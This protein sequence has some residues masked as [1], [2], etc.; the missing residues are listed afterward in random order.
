MMP[1]AWL[2]SAGCAGTLLALA[3]AADEPELPIYHVPPIV[4]V[5]IRPVAT[6]GGASAM[7]V[8]VDS[9][10]LSA[11]PTL[12][13]V[14]RE[15]PFLHVRTNSRGE[16]EI[17]ARG[18]ESRQV[19][20]L[21]DGAPVTLAWDARADVSIIPATAPQELNYVRGLSSMLH[22]PNVLGGVV[23]VKVGSSPVMP[24][25]SSYELHT[26]VDQVGAVGGTACFTA[27]FQ[28][29]GG[30]WLLRVGLG[31]RDSPGQPLA[32]GVD[33]RLPARDELRLNT[34]S[35]ITDGFL[36]LRFAGDGGTWLSLSSLGFRGERGIAAELGIPDEDARFWRY[37]RISRTLAVL[38]AGTGDRASPLGGRGDLEASL[39]YDRGRTDIDVFSSADYDA[40]DPKSPFEDGRDRT[41]TLRLLGD[42]TLGGAAD[43]RGA[44]TLAEIR[45]DEFL[46]EYESLPD[47]KARYRQRLWSLGGET[48]LRPIERGSTLRFLRFSLGGV[49]DACETPEAG[50][51]ER[52]GRISAWGGRMGVTAGL[53]GGA[54]RLHAGIS[55]RSRFPALRELYSGA[56]NRFAPNPDLRPE[57]LVT[58]ETG[59]TT[60]A[61]NAELQAVFF[62]NHLEDA[63]VRI[64][65][66]E[67]DNR[68]KRINRDKLASTGFELL[69][70]QRWG[71]FTFMGDLTV[72]SVDLSDPQAGV[73]QRPENLPELFGGASV[74][75]DLPRGFSGCVEA[76]YTGEQF[77]IDPATGED[78]RLDAGIRIDLE[79]ARCWGRHLETLLAVDNAADTAIDD[80]VGMPRPGRSV[81]LQMRFF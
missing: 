19:A 77:A 26:G 70:S 23:E 11:A 49:W 35:R 53:H 36:S 39:G 27:P 64:R 42:Q 22:G 45:H 41:L 50:G 9:L 60:Y 54:T 55:H 33:E 20:V 29:A 28:G 43:L 8:Q 7:E 79:L 76:D 14:F 34:D 69:A 75:A 40:L 63:V 32:R 18:S 12:E 65:L 16:A 1:P 73:T 44:F 21:V 10:P 37:P 61:G 5:G 15:L 67:P 17:S 4:V 6:P 25:R 80:L 38:S 66:P 58:F 72:Q 13:E 30:R 81:R 59:L 78:S 2:L 31:H 24:E 71:R 56:V 62:H 57:L 68:F 52:L 46:P 48:V 74:R 47:K 3:A 51:K